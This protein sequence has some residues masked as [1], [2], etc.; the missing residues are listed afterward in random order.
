MTSSCGSSF[1]RFTLSDVA[2]EST[3]TNV[4]MRPSE[5]EPRFQSIGGCGPCS[6]VAMAS[7]RSS[8]K[9]MFPCGRQ[10][11]STAFGPPFPQCP[12]ALSL[13]TLLISACNT[14]I[15][16]VLLTRAVFATRRRLRV[17][18]S[19]RSVGGAVLRS[20]APLNVSVW[21][22]RSIRQRV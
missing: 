1:S 17:A 6:R 16:R 13:T 14:E 20:T 11:P 9:S 15:P 4:N 22:G 2:R 18:V 8:S 21:T 19:S 10:C 12:T 3:V 7:S 5:G